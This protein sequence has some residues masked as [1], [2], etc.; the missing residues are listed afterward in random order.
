MFFKN[1]DPAYITKRFD[2][3][4][5]GEKLAQEDFASLAERTPQTH[6]ENY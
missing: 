5:N 4:D 6:G 3:L 1:G 2:V